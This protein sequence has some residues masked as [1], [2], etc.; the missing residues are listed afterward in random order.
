MSAFRVR[1]VAAKWGRI[2]SHVSAGEQARWV[3]Q[4]KPLSDRSGRGAVISCCDA[5]ASS[6][7]MDAPAHHQSN[8]LGGLTGR[9]T[10]SFN[11]V[12]A[13]SRVSHTGNPEP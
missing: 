4:V 9:S 3:P 5:T 6:L 12:R 11:A 10:Q 2:R 8:A 13:E 7:P 1:P